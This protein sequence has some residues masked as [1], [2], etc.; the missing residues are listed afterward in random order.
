[1]DVLLIAAAP[2]AIL[3]A[4]VGLAARGR[5]TSTV[6]WVTVTFIA[7]ILTVLGTMAIPG[8]V[9]GPSAIPVA[10]MVYSGLVWCLTAPFFIMR[11]DRI[12]LP[13]RAARCGRAAWRA[14]ADPGGE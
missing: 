4:L 3:A 7:D 5:E 13:R 10:L 14:A 6:A 9:G 12:C 1:M 8:L 11:P 2:A